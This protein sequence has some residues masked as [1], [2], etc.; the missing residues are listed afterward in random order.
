MA[1]LTRLHEL[2][3][4]HL[5]DAVSIRVPGCARPVACWSGSRP[6]AARGSPPCLQRA[7][8]VRDQ[9]DGGGPLPRQHS[10]SG[11][12]SDPGHAHVPVEIVR[13]DRAHHRPVAGDSAEV[14]E[15][16]LIARTHQSLMWDRIRHLQRLRQAGPGFSPTPGR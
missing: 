13:L 14:E 2:I 1:G 6:T 7:S 16:K 8:R 9:P 10:T 5:D 15:L 3:A 4:D 11:A 12:K